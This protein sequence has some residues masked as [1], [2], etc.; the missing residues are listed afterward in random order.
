MELESPEVGDLMHV[1]LTA[2]CKTNRKE[3]DKE[4]FNKAGPFSHRNSTPAFT[5]RQEDPS[6]LQQ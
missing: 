6:L 5:K 4:H 3:K 2:A 1:A